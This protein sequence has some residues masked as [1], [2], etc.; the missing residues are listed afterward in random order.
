MN[1]KAE[2]LSMSV[3]VIAAISLLVLV[4]LIVLVVGQL[5]KVP[6]AVG[7]Q[8]AVNGVCTDSCDGLEGTYTVDTANSGKAGGC[9]EG[10]VCCV[11]VA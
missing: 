6:P 1:K 9:K 5:R 3:I 4:I 8:G 2:G 11:K 10:E 7:C